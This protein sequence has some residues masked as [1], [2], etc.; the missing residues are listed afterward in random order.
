VSEPRDLAVETLYEIDQR[1]LTEAPTGLPYKTARLVKGVISHLEE[2]DAAIDGV[3]EHWRIERMPVVDRAILRLGLYE[4]RHEEDTP[5]AVVV[6]EGVRLAKL[7]STEKSG[8]F[9]NGILATLA[10]RERS[11]SAV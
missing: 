8:S 7:Y 9:V 11:S 2:L 1:N 4:L 6:S 3:S 10:E 5:T